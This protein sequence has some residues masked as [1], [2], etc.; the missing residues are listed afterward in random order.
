LVVAGEIGDGER[1]E[2]LAIGE[3]PNLAAR[4]QGLAAPGT[5]LVSAATQRL[6][7]G[8]FAVRDLGPHW[9]K[10]I[11]QPIAV[12]E[13]LHESAARNRLE[14]AGPAGLTPLT[15]RDAEVRLL[16]DRWE[17]VKGGQGQVVLLRGE[18]GIGKSRLVRV[19][20]EHVAADPTAWLST[21]WASP[22][23]QNTA[24]YPIVDVLERVVLQF[25]PG[26]A[27]EK[28]R[29]KL[30][31]WLVQY[32][33]PLAE[34]V[35]LF[36]ALL[37]L[38]EDARHPQP[39][40]PER[41]KQKTMEAM[42]R[43]M[44][45]Q[46]SEQPVLMVVEDLHWADPSTLELLHL[47]IHSVPA[48]RVMVLLTFRPEFGPPWTNRS[49]V[50][51]LTLRRLGRGP[52]AEIATWTARGKRLPQPV[53]EQMLSRTDGNPLFIE[54]LSKMVLESGL[55]READGELELV[56][57]LPPLAIPVTL[58]DSLMA[59]LDR[60]APVKTVAQLGAAL[61]REF[62]YEL[63]RAV[64]PIDDDEALQQALRQLVEAEL[65][66]EAG[67][68]PASRYV[69][70]HALIQEAAYQAMLR[71][72]RQDYHRRIAEVLAQRFPNIVGK[73]P[74]L[75]AHHYTEAGLGEQAIPF[76]THAGQHALERAAN[77]EAIAHLE[78]G[79]ELLNALPRSESIDGQELALQMG[80]APAYMA[81]KGWAS[82]E[83]EQTCRRAGDL[84]ALQD[85]FECGFGS[86]WGLW[87]NY[88][89][90][91]RLREA[92]ATGEQVMQLAVKEVDRAETG[93]EKAKLSMFE[94]MACHAVGY[95]HFYRGEFAQ[96]RR[97]AEN[98]LERFDLDV[99]R[100]IVLRHQFSSSA[101]LRMM[102][103][104]SLWML[105]HPER[106]PAIVDSAVGLTRELKHRPSEAFALAASLLFHYYRLDVDRAGQAADQLLA[107]AKQESFEIWSPFALMFR[108]WVLAER[109][110]PGAGI[111][112]TRRGIEQWQATGSYLNGTIALAM[113][114]RVLWQARRVEE[115][116]GT[117]DAGILA[118]DERAE[119]QFAPELHRLKGEILIQRGQAVAG[120]ACLHRALALAREQSARMLELRAATSL[121]R[122]SER[123]A[124]AGETR[125][126]LTGLY[127][128]FIEGFA[129]PDLQAA[130]ELIERLGGTDS[131]G[132]SE[133]R[134]PL[135]G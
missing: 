33:L 20:E 68:P 41:Q 11:A 124:K 99:E 77:V 30:E 14:A 101:A 46:A 9:L 28:K 71:S 131:T 31:G 16:Y 52:S 38:P 4:L 125:D 96:A 78:K 37:S 116:L 59:R 130:R 2:H 111:A 42:Q 127:S 61:G 113:L 49:H 6:V 86:L 58:H 119:R 98:G 117:L 123:T 56:G 48:A 76:W 35:P 115:A 55:L 25:A 26:D 43:I 92:L 129:T 1:R 103:G 7:D 47:L 79:L 27:P 97:H 24:F 60:L 135:R 109:G 126:L 73:R 112:E 69:F 13:V 83:V 118:A 5:L 18:P 29:R 82:Q 8:Y 122:L 22:Y 80:L 110:A 34:T 63:L 3:T 128:G 100:A 50:T 81:I 45:A 12:Y 120:E 15:G 64:S 106:A 39:R 87:T 51:Q 102:L 121:A 95:S 36:A 88:F 133:Q 108:G 21:C 74:E 91:G 62:S 54:E 89:L 10:G 132:R 53:L 104:C 44:L 19:L 84:S 90:R 107:L 105:G 93:H 70:K 17:Q 94:V 40:E 66:Y 134:A 72:T 75:V 23:Y 85:N 57:P 114:A 67:S 65:L 32:G